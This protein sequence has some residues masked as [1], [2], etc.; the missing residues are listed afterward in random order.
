MYMVPKVLL[1]APMMIKNTPKESQWNARKC[2]YVWW[3]SFDYSMKS[4]QKASCG[5][6]CLPLGNNRNDLFQ[7]KHSNTGITDKR[8]LNVVHSLTVDNGL[9]LLCDI[10]NALK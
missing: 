8:S 6:I 10:S 2:H 4:A 5:G 3:T 9:Q 7:N 1:E